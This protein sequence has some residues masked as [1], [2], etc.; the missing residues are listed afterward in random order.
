MGKT[1][2]GLFFI[3]ETEFIQNFKK[4]YVTYF[5]DNSINSVV[6]VYNDSGYTYSF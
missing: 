2:D 5:Q 3:E 4:Y 1:D 6:T